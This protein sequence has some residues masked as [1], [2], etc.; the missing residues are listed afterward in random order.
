MQPYTKAAQSYKKNWTLRFNLQ[1]S[2]E[3]AIVKEN[4][5]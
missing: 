4:F 5:Q 3:F 1:V 2:L